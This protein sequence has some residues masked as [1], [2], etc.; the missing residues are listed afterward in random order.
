MGGVTV[1]DVDVSSTLGATRWL[2]ASFVICDKTLSSALDTIALAS[3]VAVCITSMI[4]CLDPQ[5]LETLADR[6]DLQAQK[7]IK[8]Y[9]DFLKRQGKLEIP[10][11]T[12]FH[13]LP[14]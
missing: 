14:D 4:L 10:G 11:T 8:A 13:P 3:I 6:R 9:S 2:E 1:R 12:K 5:L 7:F